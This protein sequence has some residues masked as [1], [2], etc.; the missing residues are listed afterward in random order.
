MEKIVHDT[1]KIAFT[2]ALGVLPTSIEFDGERADVV[3]DGEL[4]TT[5]ADD[6][7]TG[8]AVLTSASGRRVSFWMPE[9]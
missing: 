4:F 9:I 8:F 5:D 2:A 3:C 1:L 7:D 6:A